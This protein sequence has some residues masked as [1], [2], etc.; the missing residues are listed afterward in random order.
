[1]AREYQLVE[2]C[3]YCLEDLTYEVESLTSFCVK[4][5]LTSGNERN[6][7]LLE[8]FANRWDDLKKLKF[9]VDVPLSLGFYP[10]WIEPLNVKEMFTLNEKCRK[11]DNLLSMDK[12]SKNINK[13]PNKNVVKRYFYLDIKHVDTDIYGNKLI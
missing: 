6:I 2:R 11:R 9:C 1:M 3:F 10:I 7:K 12:K 4:A 5:I 13:E 8:N